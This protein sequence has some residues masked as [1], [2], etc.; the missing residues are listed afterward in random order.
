V[1]RL[2]LDFVPASVVPDNIA[3]ANTTAESPA[4]SLFFIFILKFYNRT[5]KLNLD[6][7]APLF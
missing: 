5:K 1:E 6:R 7:L 4:M 2:F 3:A